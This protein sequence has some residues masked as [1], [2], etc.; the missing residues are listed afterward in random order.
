MIRVLLWAP[1]ASP[2]GGHKVQMAMTARHL[3]LTGRVHARVVVG[4]QSDFDEVDVV[5]G[6]GL[7]RMD[8]RLARRA[9]LPVVLSPVYWAKSYRLGS[10]Q[11]R[12]RWEEAKYRFRATTALSRA[13]ALGRHHDKAEGYLRWVIETAALYESVDMLLPNSRS[14]ATQLKQDLGVSTPQRVVP[15]G[16]DPSIFREAPAVSREGVLMVGRIEPHKNQL[17]LIH[18]LRGSGLPLT[19]VGDPNPDH[20]GYFDTCRREPKGSVTFLP[21]LPHDTELVG[22]YARARV[23]ALPSWFETTGLVSLEAGLVGCNVVTTS[24]GYAREY[25]Q[26]LAWYCDPANPKSITN[27]VI[28]ANSAATAPALRKRILANYTWERTAQATAEAY[29]LVI[30]GGS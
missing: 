8:V 20:L 21:S 24:R 13:A 14:E 22:V 25:L 2:F 11:P 29:E 19:I 5:H 26:D 12:S 17:G 18:A 6:F 28:E 15:N 7:T 4:L 1:A 16:V 23:H 9:R 30:A 27:A 3:E 10:S